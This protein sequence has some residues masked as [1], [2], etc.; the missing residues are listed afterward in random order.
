ML[1][2]VEM[3]WFQDAL[4]SYCEDVIKVQRKN[5][6]RKGKNVASR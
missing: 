2:Y 4:F 5:R 6:T 1:L 3:I